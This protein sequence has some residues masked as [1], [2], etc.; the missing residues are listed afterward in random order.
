M[1]KKNKIPL[2]LSSVVTLLPAVAGLLMW[3]ML[4]DKMPT[5][6]NIAGEA[7]GF[8][9]RLFAILGVPVISLI[10]QWLGIFAVM[11]DR[12]NKEQNGKVLAMILWIVPIV[13]LLV[14]CGM[15]ATVLGADIGLELLVKVPIGLMFL[16]MGNYMPKCKPNCTIGVRV[17]WTLENEENWVKTH[18]FTGR[19]WVAGGAFILVMMLVPL[20]RYVGVFFVVILLLALAPELYSYLY[21]RRQLRAGVVTGE[22]QEAK[23]TSRKKKFTVFSV[24]SGAVISLLVVMLLMTGDIRVQYKEDSFYVEANYW[25]DVEILYAD[26]EKIEYRGQDEPGT[27][28]FG[29]GNFRLLL[30]DFK[31][32]EF[33]KYIRYSY[34]GCPACIVLTIKGEV[35]VL[36]GKNAEATHEIYEELLERKGILEKR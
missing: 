4:P 19:L 24:I 25:E 7:D 28:I 2:I 20:E 30:G 17:K 14:C 6:W 27:R 35:L 10:S 8:S 23:Q 18:R 33:G 26:I 9:S 22:T 15:Y 34:A 21:Y 29:F 16:I 1:L 3:N 32:E 36:N 31:N 12:R 11:H 5:H 13:S